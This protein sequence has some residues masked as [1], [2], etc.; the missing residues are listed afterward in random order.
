[1]H[2]FLTVASLNANTKACLAKGIDWNSNTDMSKG[3]SGDYAPEANCCC[4]V[5]LRPRFKHLRSCR[6]VS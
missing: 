5:V 2:Q 4:V 6:D 1:M 3:R